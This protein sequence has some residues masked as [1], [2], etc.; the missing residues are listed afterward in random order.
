MKL[1]A[2]ILA[3]SD[4]QIVVLYIYEATEASEYFI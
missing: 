3:Q 2:I 4:L 1:K